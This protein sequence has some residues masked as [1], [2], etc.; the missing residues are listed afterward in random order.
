MS[1]VY[2]MA[3]CDFVRFRDKIWFILKLYYWIIIFV[4]I[5]KISRKEIKYPNSVGIRIQ[6]EFFSLHY[7]SS[8]IIRSY[9]SIIMQIN[10]FLCYGYGFVITNMVQINL[11]VRRFVS[12]SSL[13]KFTWLVN[14]KLRKLNMFFWEIR[15]KGVRIACSPQRSR[16]LAI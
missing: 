2:T 6:N 1:N 4:R 8:Q 16:K 10:L 12:S 15:L 14:G 7:F 13:N 3:K 9:Y 11:F 5:D